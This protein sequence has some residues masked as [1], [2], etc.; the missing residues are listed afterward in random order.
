VHLV[1]VPGAALFD[2]LK[3]GE[4]VRVLG[5]PRDA[6]VAKRS[7]TARCRDVETVQARHTSRAR[8]SGSV[9]PSSRLRR[10]TMEHLREERDLLAGRLELPDFETRFRDRPA[11]VV[12]RGRGPPEGTCGS[13]VPTCAT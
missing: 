5:G 4:T 13:C 6:R 11:L 7:R 2:Q 9:R 8:P 1:D 10:N 3:D 12:V